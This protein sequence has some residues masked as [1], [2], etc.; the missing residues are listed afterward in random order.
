MAINFRFG[1]VYYSIWANGGAS[2]LYHLAK[3]IIA[4]EQARR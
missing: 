2:P 3:R 1:T 4:L